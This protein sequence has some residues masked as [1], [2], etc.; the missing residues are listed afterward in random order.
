MM[1]AQTQNTGE[2]PTPNIDTQKFKTPWDITAHDWIKALKCILVVNKYAL[3]YVDWEGII[4][5]VV[6]KSNTIMEYLK[7]TKVDLHTNRIYEINANSLLQRIEGVGLPRL[8][9]NY[10][11]PISVDSE[12]NLVWGDQV[13]GVPHQINGI[14]KERFKDLI[15]QIH[16][17]GNTIHVE[18]KELLKHIKIIKQFN[19]GVS[20]RIDTHNDVDKHLVITSN[21]NRGVMDK[22]NI[23]GKYEGR[24]ILLNTTSVLDHLHISIDRLYP[25]VK[26][27]CRFKEIN[28]TVADNYPIIL[29]SDDGAVQF[30]IAPRLDST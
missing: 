6:D 30:I 18:P 19:Y 9:K 27:L 21:S 26:A 15:Q 29:S 8:Q 22:D 17:K 25:V 23:T 7:L 14:T 1:E 28:M 12:G 3:V 5:T 24:I 10:T 4:V 13:I 20:F 2:I 16:A 11:A